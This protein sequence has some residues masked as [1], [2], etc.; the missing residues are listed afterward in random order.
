MTGQPL[1]FAPDLIAPILDGRKVQTRR[2]LKPQ[3]PQ[4]TSGWLREMGPNAKWVAVEEPVPGR[5]PRRRVRSATC[6]YGE[7]GQT[8]PLYDEEGNAFALALLVGL[9]LQ[10]LQDISDADVAAEGCVNQT[11]ARGGF[12]PGMPIKSIFALNWCE[13]YGARAWA[14]NPWVWVLEFRMR[15][16]IVAP[17]VDPRQQDLLASAQFLRGRPRLSI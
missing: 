14:V 10:R 16:A 3:P 9:R 8:I 11:T 17:E 13:T 7:P 15:E 4:T 12:L 6:P 2:I 1:R 5:P